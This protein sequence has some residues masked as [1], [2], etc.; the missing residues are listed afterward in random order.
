MGLPPWTQ[1]QSSREVLQDS[2]LVCKLTRSIKGTWDSEDSY[3]HKDNPALPR[4]QL[5]AIF[6]L[7]RECQAEYYITESTLSWVFNHSR[8][9]SCETMWMKEA[10]R[11]NLCAQHSRRKV[12]PVP[13]P[14][15]Y[16]KKTRPSQ[17]F[18]LAL[19]SIS[20]CRTAASFKDLTCNHPSL[21]SESGM[22]LGKRTTGESPDKEGG[23]RNQYFIIQ[24][25]FFLALLLCAV[26]SVQL[27][28]LP[29]R[30]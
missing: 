25:L 5:L 26:V 8:F 23:Q 27:S 21:A 3:C 14:S 7:E 22:C 10:R 17:H 16:F 18:L 9:L 20:L 19:T 12:Y 28:S 6:T 24:G 1:A 30:A 4:H 29:L 11:Q 15:W 13:P 2:S